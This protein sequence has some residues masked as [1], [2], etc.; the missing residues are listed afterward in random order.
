ME[1]KVLLTKLKD[2]SA[3]YEVIFE[4]PQLVSFSSQNSLQSLDVFFPEKLISELR[5]KDGL[6]PPKFTNDEPFL[7]KQIPP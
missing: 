6:Q 1:F 4:K 2:R 3:E 5:D 7:K